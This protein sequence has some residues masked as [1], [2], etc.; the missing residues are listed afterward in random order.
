MI[1]HLVRTEIAILAAAREGLKKSR[2]LGLSDKARTYFVHR[3]FLSD[4]KVKVPDRAS[5]V[6]PGSD[7]HWPL[8]VE[9]W[10]KT[11]SDL[12]QFVQ[13]H[14]SQQLSQGIFRHPVAGWMGMPQILDFFS[15]HLI[16][17]N[18]QLARIKEAL[19]DSQASNPP[20]R[21]RQR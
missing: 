9:Q 4:R 1:D 16:H 15:V 12:Q 18:Y 20:Y 11:R 5:Q 17:H 7:L 10:Q 8:L 19:R 3:I 21:H 2:R 13:D 14:D 6:L